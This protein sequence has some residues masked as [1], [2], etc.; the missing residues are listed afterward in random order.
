MSDPHDDP[1]D[2]ADDPG[3]GAGDAAEGNDAEKDPQVAVDAFLDEAEAVF[4]EY[5][6]GYVDADVALSRLR[7]GIDDLASATGE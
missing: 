2:G 7:R 1:T 6:Q 4:E 3:D 5:D